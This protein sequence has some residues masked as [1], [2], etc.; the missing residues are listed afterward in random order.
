MILPGNL[1]LYFEFKLVPIL[2]VSILNLLVDIQDAAPE[3]L[4]IMAAFSNSSGAS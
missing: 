3:A 2:P 4:L 1:L